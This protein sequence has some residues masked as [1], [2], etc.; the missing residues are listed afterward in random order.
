MHRKFV[1][2]LL[3]DENPRAYMIQEERIKELTVNGVIG[4]DKQKNIFFPVP[5]IPQMFTRCVCCA[6]EWRI[7]RN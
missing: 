3:F 7:G 2:Q 6:D 5:Y 4:V 1:E